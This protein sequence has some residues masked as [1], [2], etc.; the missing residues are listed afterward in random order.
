MPSGLE[1]C[2]ATLGLLGLR[3]HP[4][5]SARASYGLGRTSCLWRKYFDEGEL[6]GVGRLSVFALRASPDKLADGWSGR[7]CLGALRCRGGGR[8]WLTEV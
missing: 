1:H 8:S 2:L 3:G 5:S 4:C 6:G 7:F